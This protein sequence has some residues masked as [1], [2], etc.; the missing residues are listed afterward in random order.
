[1]AE[2][3]GVRGKR[4]LITGATGGIGLAAAVKLAQLGAQLAIVARDEARASEAVQR[5]AAKSGSNA[6]V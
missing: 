6:P 4:V 3:T 1:M 2:W 5:I